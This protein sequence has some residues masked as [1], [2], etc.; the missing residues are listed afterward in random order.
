MRRF[1]A[2]LVMMLTLIAALA[3][4][5]QSV[6]E[7]STDAMEYG[8]GTQLTYAITKRDAT[9]YDAANYPNLTSG[10]KNLD[11]IDIKGAVMKRLDTAGVRNA[12]VELTKG[13]NENVGYQVKVSFSPLS[14]TDEANVKELLAYTGSLSV[15]TVGDDTCMYADKSQL[16]KTSDLASLVY[17]GTSPYPSINVKYTDDMDNLIKAAGTAATNHKNDTKTSDTKSARHF[18]ADTTTG[19]STS[20]TDDESTKLYLWVNKTTDD[21]YNKAYGM[22]GARVDEDVKK[23]VLAVL[24]TSDYSST[25]KAIRVTSDIDGNAFTISTARAFVNSLNSTDYGFDISYLYENS[26]YADFG[27]SALKNTYLAVGISLAVICL[28]LLA[29]YGLSGLSASLTLLVSLFVSFILFNLL[30]FEFSIAGIA[31]M[32]VVACLSLFISANYFE[33][34]K[35]EILKGRS[36][37]KANREG[38]HKAF[39]GG[40][41]VAIVAFVASLFSFLISLG[42]FRTFFGAIMVGSIVAFVLTNFLD[43][44][45]TYWLVKDTEKNDKPYFSFRGLKAKPAKPVAFV[46]SKGNGRKLPLYLVAGISAVL[47]GVALPVSYGLNAGQYAFFNSADQY[48]TGYNLTVVFKDSA[49]SYEPLSTKANYLDYLVMI[50]TNAKDGK[51][52]MVDTVSK[53]KSDQA[54][55]TY[56]EATAFVNIVEKTDPD[57]GSTYY[58]HYFSVNVNKDLSALVDPDNNLSVLDIIKLTMQDSTQEMQVSSYNVAPLNDSHYMNDS[59]SILAEPTEAANLPHDTNNLFLLIGVLSAFCC[60]YVLV[61]FGLNLFLTEVTSGTVFALLEVG[62]LSAT[63]LAYNPYTGFLLLAALFVFDLVLIPLFADNHIVIKEQ[64]LKGKATSEQKADIANA[65]ILRALPSVVIPLIGFVLISLTAFMIDSALVSYSVLGVLLPV[66]ALAVLLLF[67]TNFYYLL[68]SHITFRPVVD[69]FHNRQSQ[70]RGKKD[71]KPVAPVVSADGNVYV[72]PELPHETVIP[73][74]NDFH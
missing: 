36:P 41:D 65:V 22:N 59:Y 72:D 31:G 45:V 44:W 74:L 10:I 64:G 60:I 69:W 1:L 49:Q 40:L 4:N 21:T 62:L 43:K 34:V 54:S 52:L 61:R 23:K 16:F 6:L 58:I 50:G 73:G 71:K 9:L 51:Y 42:S 48:A 70:R 17:N 35:Q 5:M 30:G 39:F 66:V 46:T 19:D 55:F 63:R 33:H 47:A 28:G 14:A 15:C 7:N 24:K 67:A 11:E 32:A 56:Q 13:N 38:Y 25:D 2:Y 12:D 53:E 57:D 29:F 8:K 18:D 37:E 26:I 68:T 20:T 3:F 27:T